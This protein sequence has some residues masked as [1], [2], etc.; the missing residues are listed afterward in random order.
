M[1]WHWIASGR[2]GNKCRLY[3]VYGSH[4][5]FEIVRA[6]DHWSLRISRQM[7]PLALMFGW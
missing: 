7:E 4:S 6:G 1:G 5:P 3:Q 2:A